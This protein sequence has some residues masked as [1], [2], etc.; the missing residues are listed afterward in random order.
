MTIKLRSIEVDHNTAEVL[1]ARAAA[2]GV[3]VSQIVADLA[4]T[5]PPPDL[6]VIAEAKE[7]PWSAAALAEDARRLAEFK[8]TRQGVRWEEVKTWMQSWHTANEL[9]PPKPGQ[10]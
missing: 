3:S 5:T 6:Q 4:W 9:K 7:G 8:R 1:E 10:L 2:R